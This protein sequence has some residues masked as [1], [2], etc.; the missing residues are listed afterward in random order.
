MRRDVQEIFRATPMGKQVMMFSATLSTDI[1]PICKKFMQSPLEIFVDDETKLTL[2]G[3][4]QYYIKLEEKEKNRKLNEL[5]DQL[6]FNQV[7][8]F[9]KSTVRANELNKL[10]VE[11]NFPSIAVHSGI[12]QEERIKRYTLFK[13]FNKR[14]C[15]ATDVFGRGIDIERI[16]LAINYDLPADPDSYLHRVGRAGRFGTK[17]LSI[18]FVSSAEDAVVLDKIME[19]FEVELEKFPEGGI[20]AST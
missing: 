20:D 5:L 11:C 1:R 10:L 7:I 15:V 9:V 14:I 6:E 12:S 2:H 17:G 3:L 13:E 16:N 8:I 18:S 19:R 4:Q